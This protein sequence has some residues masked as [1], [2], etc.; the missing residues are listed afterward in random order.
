MIRR[1]E[2]VSHV[3]ILWRLWGFAKKLKGFH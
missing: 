1:Q 2:K 3:N